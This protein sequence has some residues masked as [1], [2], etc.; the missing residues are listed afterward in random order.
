MSTKDDATTFPFENLTDLVVTAN[1][2]T[3]TLP[4]GPLHSVIIQPVTTGVE[5]AFA[6]APT[7]GFPLEADKPFQLINRNLGGKKLF[8]I[9]GTNTNLIKIMVEHGTGN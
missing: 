4:D 1:E 9:N 2:A 7:V 6:D 5:I 3:V 8:F